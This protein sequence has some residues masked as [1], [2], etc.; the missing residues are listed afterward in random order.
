MTELFTALQYHFFSKVEKNPGVR[1][2]SLSYMV[3][4][5]TAQKQPADSISENEN[6]TQVKLQHMFNI[7]FE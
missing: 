3:E 6:V 7:C 5:Q 1:E 4:C 2:I